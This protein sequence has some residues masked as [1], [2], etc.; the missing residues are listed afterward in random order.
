MKLKKSYKELNNKYK[1]IEVENELD[2]RDKIYIL[3]LLDDFKDDLVSIPIVLEQFNHTDN[4]TNLL[5]EFY[6]E[7]F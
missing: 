1:N 4:M 5:N 2:K 6:N 7:F 3:S